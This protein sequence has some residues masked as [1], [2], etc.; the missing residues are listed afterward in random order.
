MTRNVRMCID[1]YFNRIRKFFRNHLGEIIAVVAMVIS[2][3]TCIISYQS[4]NLSKWANTK[5]DKANNLSNEA[6][7]IADKANNLSNEAIQLSKEANKIAKQNND[8][9]KIKFF[10]ENGDIIN[11]M[12][13]KEK[14]NF[15][16]MFKLSFENDQILQYFFNKYNIKQLQDNN[17][18]IKN[19]DFITYS[20]FSENTNVIDTLKIINQIQY[21]ENFVDVHK[22]IY[23][24]VLSEK[25]LD[26][27]IIRLEPN[28]SIA[29]K[30]E[31][32]ITV[33][34]ANKNYYYYYKR[35]LFDKNDVGLLF[36]YFHYRDLHKNTN[37]LLGLIRVLDTLVKFN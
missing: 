21:E 32:P 24:N 3:S 17:K 37:D 29:E 4:N 13:D 36:V 23:F 12:N 1:I 9:E 27:I 8:V 28:I 14:N 34:L 33:S 19:I 18:I 35:I 16:S 6:N 5:A 2:I 20:Y 22:N 11:N 26:S 7:K 10:T 25:K 31:D 30:A 15:F